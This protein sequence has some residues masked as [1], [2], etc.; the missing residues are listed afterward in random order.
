MGLGGNERGM[1]AATTGE[2]EFNKWKE[3]FKMQ[4]HKK[5]KPEQ[6]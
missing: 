5:L 4:D 6:A 1:S 3:G 2:K